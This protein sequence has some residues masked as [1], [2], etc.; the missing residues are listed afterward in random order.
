MIR[1][2]LQEV[3]RGGGRT[4]A[5]RLAGVVA[6][7]LWS[8]AVLVASDGA[9]GT[10]T[11]DVTQRDGVY[12]V[13]AT[14]TVAEPS[15]VAFA[16]LTDYAAIP[17]FMPEVRTSRVVH[18]D[19]DRVVVEQEAI[20]RFMMFSKRVHLVLD[21]Q[22]HRDRIRFT[23][24]CGQSF[25]RYQGT[26]TIEER[27]GETQITYE[28][29]AQPSFDVPAFLLRR[30]FKRDASQMIERLKSEILTRAGR[31]RS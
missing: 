19:G 28:L 9:Q 10:P 22:Q 27:A 8:G 5:R 4:T 30:L 20:A 16:A 12:A 3:T 17:R 29:S 15:S 6:A 7:V 18:Q 31:N 2:T 24:R 25:A 11:V 23:D 1:H 26:W 21:V 13:S 14:F